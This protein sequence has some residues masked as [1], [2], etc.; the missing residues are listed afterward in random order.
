MQTKTTRDQQ[1]IRIDVVLASSCQA[2]CRLLTKTKNQEAKLGATKKTQKGKPFYQQENEEGFGQLQTS[3]GEGVEGVSGNTGVD[4]LGLG[5]KLLPLLSNMTRKKVPGVQ[6]PPEYADS[7]R[8]ARALG[9][10]FLYGNDP[11]ADA[12]SLAMNTTQRNSLRGAKGFGQTMTAI[13]LAS[14]KAQDNLNKYLMAQKQM[15]VQQLGLG[16]KYDMM[17]GQTRMELQMLA[18]RDAQA[19]NVMNRKY[20]NANLS[21]LLTNTDPYKDIDLGETS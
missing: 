14:T 4:L 15:G 18:N 1:T 13:N 7:A 2:A 16:D 10:S 17:K 8:R 21:A 3:L 12:Q 6:V 5:S 19:Q 20:Q 9:K 11:L